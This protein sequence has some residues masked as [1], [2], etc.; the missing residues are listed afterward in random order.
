MPSDEYQLDDRLTQFNIDGRRDLIQ[1]ERHARPPLPA[2]APAIA[3]HLVFQNDLIGLADERRACLNICSE[4]GLVPNGE[5]NDQIRA[6]REGLSLK[7][8]RHTEYSSYTLVDEGMADAANF[9]LWTDRNLPWEDVPGRLLV[10][11]VIG[12][13]AANAPIWSSTDEFNW[14]S[15]PPL[16]SS[17]VMGGTT[18]IESDLQISASGH[19][20]FL[21]KTSSTEPSRIGRLLQ[22]LIEVES[23]GALSLYAWKDA[24]EIGPVLGEAES[25]LGKIVQRLTAIGEETD[26]SILADLTE[27]SA[28]HEATTARTHFRLNASLAYHDIVVRRLTELREERIPGSQRLANFILRRLNPAASTYRA[29]L[30]RQEETAERINRAAQLLRGRI[31]VAIGQ[32]N[33]Q[34]LKSMDERAE[35]QYKLQ[36]T[37]EGLSV[38]AITYYALGILAYIAAVIAGQVDT[39]GVKEIVGFSVPFVL[40][41]VWF[42]VN[43]L[44][45]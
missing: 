39:F 20:R 31:E 37:V 14:D 4:L 42:S 21:V 16:C 27:L 12:V 8:E 19:T 41:A 6:S 35:A 32:Q 26:E 5:L 1:A 23:Y 25:R 40:F 9:D 11:L 24:K 38:V 10:S 13:E 36:R 22:R 45:K 33:Q 15:T 28:F 17:L 18:V 2:S 34:L 43:R 3:Q 30:V 44:R 7:W 29:I